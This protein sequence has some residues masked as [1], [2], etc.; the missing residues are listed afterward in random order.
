MDGM[1]VGPPGREV[2]SQ[3]MD[4]APYVFGPLAEACAALSPEEVRF[5]MFPAEPVHD[6]AGGSHAE[7]PACGWEISAGGTTVSGPL[8]TMSFVALWNEDVASVAGM[9]VG[10]TLESPEWMMDVPFV[11]VHP[12]GFLQAVSYDAVNGRFCRSILYPD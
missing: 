6:G 4:V 5:T 2:P 12:S 8:S 10:M 3:V 1:M 7:P 11:H 9:R